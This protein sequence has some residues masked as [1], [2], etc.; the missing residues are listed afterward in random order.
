M[1]ILEM[2]YRLKQT[3]KYANAIGQDVAE[4][5][6]GGFGVLT[7]HGELTAKLFYG[8]DH[9][10]TNLS[11]RKRFSLGLLSRR[12]ITDAGV[13]F[14]VDAF[15]NTTE[16]ENFNFHDAG[17]GSTAEAVGQTGLI[18][19]WGGARVSGTQS[20]PAANQYRSVGTITFTGSFAIVEHGIFSASSSGT[21]WDRSLFSAINVV[22]TDS[23]QFTY[24]LTVNSG[25]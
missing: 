9:P 5:I 12:S 4:A 13:A 19:P 24:T 15:Q 2:L 25:G 17:T 10:I 23:I 20:E 21:L 16:I 1:N 6:A 3:R 14:M 11:P 8:P 18:T 22:N 7:M